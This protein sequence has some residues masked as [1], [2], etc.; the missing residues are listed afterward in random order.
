MYINSAHTLIKKKSFNVIFNEK[1]NTSGAFN[2]VYLIQQGMTKLELLKEK[3]IPVHEQDKIYC[4]CF[5]V[6]E[7]Y[8]ICWS[9]GLVISTD[10]RTGHVV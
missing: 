2:A 1:C 7:I 4:L 3:K 6:M 9:V 8:K 10:K 5:I